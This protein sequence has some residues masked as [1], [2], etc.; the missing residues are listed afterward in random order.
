M[1]KHIIQSSIISKIT[2]KSSNIYV[3]TSKNTVAHTIK[4]TK[5]TSN[6]LQLITIICP[7]TTTVFVH[8]VFEFGSRRTAKRVEKFFVS[9][10]IADV[11]DD[12]L[13]P[14]RVR[15]VS[16]GYQH[17]RIRQQ[18]VRA[19]NSVKTLHLTTDQSVEFGCIHTEKS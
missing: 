4:S 6:A 5:S 16:V 13:F 19:E 9:T 18:S 1:H 2:N 10:I 8:I 7:F 11:Y 12:P 15:W 17:S 3:S 14:G